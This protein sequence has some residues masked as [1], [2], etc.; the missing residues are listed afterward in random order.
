[1]KINVPLMT[2]DSLY[3]SKDGYAEIDFGLGNI[4]QIDEEMELISSI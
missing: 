3:A 4:T 2:C 1:M